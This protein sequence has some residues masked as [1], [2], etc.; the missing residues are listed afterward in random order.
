MTTAPATGNA[1]TRAL[2][3]LTRVVGRATAW[4]IIPMVGSLV[5]EV[6]ARYLFD[7][8]TIWAYDMTFMLYGTF[9]MLGLDSSTSFTRVSRFC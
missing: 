8:P 2:D 6:G 5:Y 7:A 4:L 3:T 1:L 9:F